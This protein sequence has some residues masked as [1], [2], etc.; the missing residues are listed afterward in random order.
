MWL[1]LQLLVVVASLLPT[2]HALFAEDAGKLDFLIATA[3][4]GPVAAAFQL[5]DDE[6]VIVTGGSS[7]CHVAGRS[8]ATGRLLWRRDAALQQNFDVGSKRSCLVTMAGQTV[9]TVDQSTAMVR[10]WSGTDGNLLWD[11]QQQFEGIVSQIWAVGSDYVAFGVENSNAVVLNAMSGEIAADKEA[12]SVRPSDDDNERKQVFCDA[13]KTSV[14]VQENGLVAVSAEVPIG[15]VLGLSVDQ[16]WLLGCKANEISVLATSRRG[17]TALVTFTDDGGANIAWTAEEGLAQ[18]SSAL[19]LDASHESFIKDAGQEKDI[20]QFSSRLASQWKEVTS[21]LASLSLSSSETAMVRGRDHLFG[22]VKIAVL[23]SDS[24]H[25][26]FGLETAGPKRTSLRFQFDLPEDARWHRMIHGSVNSEKGTHGINGGAHTREV[27]ILSNKGTTVEWICMDGTSGDVYDKGAVS[28]VS[29]IVQVIPLAGKGKCRQDAILMLE[30]HS[31]V[32]VAG[33]SE[34]S[35]GTI[36]NMYAHYL[37]KKSA[38]LNSFGITV[39]TD[40]GSVATYLV[41]SA[42]FPGEEIVAVAY[43]P[44]EEVI[45]SPCSVLGDD[46]LLLKYLNPHLTV[47][48]TME[49]QSDD[50]V[51]VGEEFPLKPKKSKQKRKPVGVTQ[52]GEMPKTEDKPNFFVNVVDTV[53]GRVLYRASHANALRSPRPS[54]LVSENWVF[55]TFTNAKTRKAELGVLSL[56]EGMIDKNGLTAFNSPEQLTSFSSLDARETKP[57]VLAKTF[58]IPMPATALGM[59]STRSGISGRQLL[60]AGFDGTIHAIGRKMLEP[61]RPLGQVKDTEKKEGLVQYHELI[62]KVSYMALSH[63]Q[64]VES[65][66]SIITAPTDVESQT[67]ILA[68]GGPDIFFTRTSPSKGFD[69]LPD[70]FNRVLLSIVVA[71]LVAAL[72]TLRQLVAKKKVKQGWV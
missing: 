23:L 26:V 44:R 24:A 62:Q 41:G 55:Y 46:S 47:I 50:A 7:S 49:S 2:A 52:P 20:L 29:P 53:S 33:R 11:Q 34:D 22:F 68:F 18:V 13:S 28:V 17:T 43:P 12:D 48:V 30:D 27:L 42:V 40:G 66:Q 1:L 56:Y 70:N 60:L 64:T 51:E 19:M 14:R 61:R 57:V 54:A 10:G 58:T 71:G 21:L 45:Q 9:V 32:S 15:E 59:T 35:L 38:T 39:G 72:V 5:E 3:G 8:R 65:V 31:L 37:D 6:D 69:L 16:V 4:H 25:R 63:N 67:L 36:S